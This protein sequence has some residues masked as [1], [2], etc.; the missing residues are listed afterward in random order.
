MFKQLG[1]EGRPA[2]VPYSNSGRAVA[3]ELRGAHGQQEPRQN[4]RN[5]ST[6]RK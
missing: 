2:F 1:L 3:E 5:A 4:Y 6:R